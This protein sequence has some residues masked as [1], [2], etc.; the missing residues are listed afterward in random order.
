M[1]LNV[2]TPIR[3][4]TA[5]AF[6]V[7]PTGAALGAEVRCGDLRSLD[8]ID[9]A[10]VLKFVLEGAINAGTR[11]ESAAGP[12]LH[13]HDDASIRRTAAFDGP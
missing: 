9:F 11:A 8:D 6:D 2:D 5:P 4:A 3:R 7:I 13:R 12:T 10:R 1:T